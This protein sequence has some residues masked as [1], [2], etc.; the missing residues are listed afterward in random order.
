M[1][2]FYKCVCIPVRRAY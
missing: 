2:V 1:Y